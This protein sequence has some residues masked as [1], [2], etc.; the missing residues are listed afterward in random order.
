MYQTLSAE[1]RNGR[2]KLLDKAKIP[3]GARMLVTVIQEDDGQFWQNVSQTSL[4]NIWANTDDDI[5]EKLIRK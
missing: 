2:I 4:E 5:Y 3:E 1:M